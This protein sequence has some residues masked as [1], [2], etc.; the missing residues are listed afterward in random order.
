VVILWGNNMAEMH[1]VLFSRLMDRRSRGERVTL[2]D[3]TTRRTRT[4]AFADHVLVF[5]P[6]GDLAHRQRHRRT[7]SSPTTPST[8]PSSSASATSARTPSAP[9]ST[10]RR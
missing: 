1:P 5:K 9:T 3:L 4:S 2:I 10:A 6:H 8:A 7:C